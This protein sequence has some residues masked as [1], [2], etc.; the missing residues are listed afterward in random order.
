LLDNIVAHIADPNDPDDIAAKEKGSAPLT[1]DKEAAYND[2]I[3]YNWDGLRY[4]SNPDRAPRDENTE[5]LDESVLDRTTIQLYAEGL[6]GGDKATIDGLMDHI[7][8]L[9]ETDQDDTFKVD[10]II[11]YFQN[12]FGIA[13]SGDG[14]ETD[15]RFV[16]NDLGDGIRWDNRLNWMA[17]ETPDDGDNVDLAGNWVEYGG[18]FEIGNLDLGS[19]GR[20]DVNSGK[21]TVEGDLEVGARG[22]TVTTKAAGQF[23]LDGY[24]DS[25]RL[26]IEV[27]GGRFAN[28]GD[29]SGEASINVSGG[30]ALLGVDD[31]SMVL[32]DG[33]ELRIEGSDAKVGF[34]GSDGGNAIVQMADDAVLTFDADA[35]GFSGIREFRSGYF[36]QQGTDVQSGLSLDGQLQIDL[37]GYTGGAGTQ[38]LIHVDALT[39]VF[40]DIH[41]HGLSDLDARVVTDYE[42]DE[43]RLELTEGAG[44]V[45]HHVIGDDGFG[46]DEAS[47]LWAALTAGQG[48][49]DDTG[50]GIFAEDDPLPEL[51]GL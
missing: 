33:S 26:T 37:S 6:L 3:V 47:D 22:G 38:S 17:E 23:W 20:L 21:L 41:V 7:Q 49:Y 16:P 15:H 12:G 24:A 44:A 19:G 43:V 13:P 48:T 39:G 14:S 36:D 11:A 8:S 10:D 45:S 31:A 28:T 5:D 46:G 27:E 1:I 50:T 4:L 34:D 32:G 51:L 35:D 30:Q 9:A 2:T 18:T 42:T 40:D 29:F 25:D